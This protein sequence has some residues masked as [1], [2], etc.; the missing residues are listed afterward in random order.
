MASVGS[1]VV[2][3]MTADASQ[4]DL[5]MK[6]A[7]KA[8]KN[9]ENTTKKANQQLRFM[10]GGLGQVGHQ[11][12]DVAVQ[13]QMGQN[14]ML[15]FGQ[16]GSQVASLF[17]PGGALIGAVLAVGA[18][19]ATSLMPSVFGATEAQ[20][21]LKEETENLA[22]RYDDLTAA[23]KRYAKN[24]VN[25][26]I[27]QNN[28]LIEQATRKQNNLSLAITSNTQTFNNMKNAVDNNNTALGF[29]V[30]GGVDFT[31]HMVLMKASASGAT[32]EIENQQVE[33]DTASQSNV[34][35]AEK[36]DDTT[37]AYIKFEEKMTLANIRLAEGTLGVQLYNIATSNMTEQEKLVASAKAEHLHI[38]KQLNEEN[39]KAGN[40]PNQDAENVL[41][42]GISQEMGLIDQEIKQRKRVEKEQQLIQR[43]QL[44]RFEDMRAEYVLEAASIGKSA[45][46]IEILTMRHQ[47]LG[48][49]QIKEI[50]RLKELIKVRQE[51]AGATKLNDTFLAKSSKEKTLQMISDA[52][53][54]TEGVGR[55]SKKMAA[56]QKTVQIGQAVMNT[57]AAASKA[58]ATYGVPLGIPFAAMAVAQGMAHVNAIKSAS[59]DGGGFTGR[60]ARTG[61]IDGK[62]GF[63]A[64]LH[65]N[66]TVIDH[67]RGSGGMGESI[68][69]NQSINVTTGVQDTVR[70]EILNLMPQI[71][72]TAQN[73][74]LS[75][76]MR[77]GSYSKQ[78]MGK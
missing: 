42:Q 52:K 65:P 7:A 43:A 67:T 32:T 24:K 57:Y 73:A 9:Y 58:I 71:A 33:I 22:D 40:I 50:L 17:G 76:R 11:V 41:V 14:A 15:V 21:R 29:L 75:A 28:D 69:V 2:I 55:H 44:E 49:E 51:A 77:G 56:I 5:G 70:A 26:V 23:Q 16:Q 31:R 20:K 12:Q 63:P 30:R 45:E 8:T 59:F 19:L 39:G 78:L 34:K 74:V 60:G 35:L 37:D 13:L 36:V 6:R 72:E 48:E 54:L 38:Q 4:V 66:E 3:K 46:E 1:N 47:G 61:G 10:R 18:A 62:G 68:V 27:E 25:E 53:T 64:I